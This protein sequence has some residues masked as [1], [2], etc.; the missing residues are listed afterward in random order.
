MKALVV[1]PHKPDS[2]ELRNVTKPVPSERQVLLETL[3]V[4]ID[5]T[6]REINEGAYG[7]PPEGSDFLVLGHEALTRISAVGEYVKG[8]SPGDLVVP[9]VRRPCWENCLNCR[10]VK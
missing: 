6:D 1:T 8:F 9:T 3:C 10:K 2:I 7:A 4:G 5:G